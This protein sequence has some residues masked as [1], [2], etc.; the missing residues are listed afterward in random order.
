MPDEV[1]MSIRDDHPT[2]ATGIDAVIPTESKSPPPDES[3]TTL[4]RAIEEVRDEARDR[5]KRTDAR[6][7]KLEGKASAQATTLSH[8]GSEVSKLASQHAE[9]ATAQVSVAKAAGIASE[10][11]AQAMSRVSTSQDDTRKMVESAMIIQKGVIS[12][13]MAQAVSPIAKAVDD[14]TKRDASAKTERAKTNEAMGAVLDELG[15]GDLA[16]LGQNTKP[17]EKPPERSLKQTS[18]RSWL[19]ALSGTLAFLTV[20]IELALKL[21]GH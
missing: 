14:L 7:E 18:K 2:P 12:A 17:G 10:L 21:L 3:T 19:A 6:L 15:I 13:E 9:L 1:K 4:L 5:D 16:E 8:L 11:A 20:A